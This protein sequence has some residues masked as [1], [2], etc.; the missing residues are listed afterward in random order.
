M[1]SDNSSSSAAAPPPAGK[2]R[3]CPC[4]R[5]M[6]SLTHDFHSVCVI[7]RNRDCDMENRCDECN[8]VPDDVIQTYVR[9]RQ[10][11]K[12]RLLSK[13]RRKSA[14]QS[15]TVTVDVEVPPASAADISSS[16]SPPSGASVA[17]AAATSVPPSV[18]PVQGVTFDRVKDLLAS[19]SQSLEARFTII[20][21]R[22]S[23]G[24]PSN[25]VD[26]NV[27]QD[28]LTLNSFPAPSV[29]IGRSKPTPDRAPCV[30][31]S[32]SLGYS[33]GEPTAADLEALHGYVLNFFLSSLRGV[34]IH[35]LDNSF[36]LSGESLRDSVVPHRA[37]LCDP[38]SPIPGSSRDS[39]SV[40]PFLCSL[41]GVTTPFPASV[42]EPAD[43]FPSLGFGP[44]GFSSSSSSSSS[45][46][47]FHH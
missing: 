41:V 19:F 31:Y 46:D 33:L 34:V 43:A 21:N 38:L 6:S 3:R 10:S 26:R 22:I 7:C 8:D 39:D 40:V 35:A 47:V 30:P 11:L 5:R 12:C 20:D 24:L 27:S 13:Q 2:V 44:I 42:A 15:Q 23:Q 14:L 36:A 25:A 16:P 45:S 4:G 28:F 9:H 32:D 1:D 29:V 17:S 37:H 18:T